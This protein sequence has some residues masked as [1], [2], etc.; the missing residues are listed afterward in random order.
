VLLVGA[1]IL[2]RKRQGGVTQHPQLQIRNP[3]DLG[4]V[5]QLA[6]L[7]A[8]ILLFAKAVAS[9]A[10]NTGLFLLAAVSAIADVDALTLSMARLAGGQ[11]G[12]SDAAVAILIAASVNTASKAAIA[13]FV[14][15]MRIGAIVGGASVL[16]IAALAIAFVTLR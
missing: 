5:L 16:A 1:G 13:A 8:V 6:G 11:V 9:Q 3:F 12:V 14:G 7:I 10:G 4:I 2:L 15:G